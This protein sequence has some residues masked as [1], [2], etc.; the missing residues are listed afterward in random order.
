VPARESKSPRK[1]GKPTKAREI[2]EKA[3]AA[4]CSL[5]ERAKAP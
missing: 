2:D 5:R 1:Q 4:H 3:D